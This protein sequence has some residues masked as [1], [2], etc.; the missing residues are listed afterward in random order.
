MNFELLHPADQLVEM[1]NRIYGC[2]MTTTSGGN[3]SIRDENGD[4]WITPSGVDKGNLTRDD[5]MQVKPDGS[6]I[7]KHK[8]SI[9]LPFH[10]DIYGA[11]PDIFGVVHAHPPVMVGFSVIRRE[12]DTRIL[13]DAWR[14]CGPVAQVPYDV[15]GSQELDANINACFKAGY[16]AVLMDNHGVVCGARNLLEAFKIFETVTLTGEAELNAMRLGGV[17]ALNEE[18]LKNA[19]C[20]KALPEAAGEMTMSEEEGKR[21]AQMCAFA[22]RCYNRKFLSAIQG[23]ISVRFEGGMLI[24]PAGRDHMNLKPDEIVRVKDGCCEIGKLPGEEAQL[25]LKIY[26]AQPEVNSIIITHAPAIM[27]FAAA[28]KAFTSETMSEGYVILGRVMHEKCENG[29]LDE[30]KIAAMFGYRKNVVQ[31]DNRFAIVT[32]N[33][34]LKAFERTE[35]LEYGAASEIAAYGLGRPIP[36]TEE[37]INYTNEQLGL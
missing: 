21:R 14:I 1:M 23:C 5:I 35:V 7:G 17:H 8:P 24:T 31:L 13:P 32:G 25:H 37:E 19:A 26:E 15:A 30:D 28:G 2:G 27:G 34:L 10:R 3:L 12:P 36:L 18:Q 20:A 16:N 11:R 9:E 22:R 33:S 4:I 29:V 6:Y